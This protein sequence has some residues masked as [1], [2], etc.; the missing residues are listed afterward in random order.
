VANAVRGPTV[1]TARTP[2]MDAAA[3]RMAGPTAEWPM[4]SGY[5][6]VLGWC[7]ADGGGDDPR[8]TMSTAIPAATSTAESALAGCGSSARWALT[9]A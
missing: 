1:T 2:V 3:A 5:V 4:R 6:V 9:S 8:S 7:R